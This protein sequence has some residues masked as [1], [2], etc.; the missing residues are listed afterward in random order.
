MMGNLRRGL[1]PGIFALLLLGCLGLSISGSR[2]AGV[3][4]QEGEMG[5]A[6]LVVVRSADQPDRLELNGRLLLAPVDSHLGPP[7]ISPDGRY[8]AVTQV[9]RGNET[10]HLAQIHLFD[11]AGG[12]G[13][14]PEM[15]PEMVPEMVRIMGHS[16]TWLDAGEGFTFLRSEPPTH[17]LAPRSGDAAAQIYAYDLRTGEVQP[18]QAADAPQAR[19]DQP[20]EQPPEQPTAAQQTIPAP[21]PAYPEFIR[22]AH[23]PE[24][25]CRNVPD[26]QVDLI[27]FEEYVARSVPAEVPVSWSLETLAA[28][29]VAARTYAWYQIRQN[30]PNYDVTDWANFQMMCDQR[31]PRS[32]LAVSLTAGQYLT[33]QDDPAQ[34]PIIAMY[35]AK[36]GHPTLD[37]PNVSYLRGVPDWAGLGE[38]RWG[39]GYGLSQWG[40]QRRAAV[41]QPYRQLL[42]HYYTGVHLQNALNPSQ[43][44]G[45]L[46]GLEPG[47][48][49]PPGGLRWASLTPRWPL[50]TALTIR[51]EPPTESAHTLP[52]TP[53]QI[54]TLSARSGVWPSLADLPEG[55]QVQLTLLVSDTIQDAITLTVDRTPPA[56]PLLQGPVEVET[57]TATV[58][59]EGEPGSKVGL[60]GGWRWPADALSQ[61]PGTGRLVNGADGPI[62]TAVAG[63]DLPGIWYGPYTQALPHGAT[64]RARFHLSLGDYAGLLPAESAVPGLLPDQP[65]ARLD[66]TDVGGTVRLG[67]RD[68]WPSDFDPASPFTHI[69]VDFHIFNPPEGLE[70]RVHW[71]G[72]ANL[73]L[74]QVEIFRLQGAT[75]QFTPL[76]L[77]PDSPGVDQVT[78]TAL[79]FDPA[80]NASPPVTHTIRIVDDGPP[81]L[82]GLQ[83]PQGWQSA[84]PLLITAQVVDV[85]SGLDTSRGR[86]VVGGQSVPLTFER[87]DAPWTEQTVSASVESLAEGVH[88]AFLSVYDMAGFELRQTF[89]L[90]VDRTPP[91]VSASGQAV[92]TLL[93][94]SDLWVNQPVTI[95]I[96]AQDAL[97]GI[98]DQG[99]VAYVL[100]QAPYA[101]YEGPFL[102]SQEGMQTIRYWARDRAENY[103]WSHF[104]RVGIDLTPPVVQAA[105]SQPVPG[106]GQISWQ[107]SDA[108]TGVAGYQVGIWAE[109]GWSVLAEGVAA[110]GLFTL[111]LDEWMADAEPIRLGVSAWDGVGNQ[112]DWQSALLTP[113]QGHWLYLPAVGRGE[114][115]RE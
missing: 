50:P 40:A 68:L 39:H 37:N 36:N 67:L 49:L 22:V 15:S 11:L 76:R 4:A 52:V 29:A 62:L 23:H 3:S 75:A 72:Q 71:M 34:R 44:L 95:T 89:Q 96:Q 7:R 63:E 91:T 108:W 105:I 20:P 56:S 16:V 61:T 66:V 12:S 1:R 51:V 28:Q 114:W 80:G 73:S 31:Y 93:P 25:G 59:I 103:T 30:R 99:G 86:V 58:Q 102:L 107:A 104:Y 33:A 17:G 69:P 24:N 35:S 21:P 60:S 57:L 38:V 55:S 9:P 46:F 94:D 48:Y 27:P 90:R 81:A 77:L 64:Y 19:G 65:I 5:E 13:A 32:D 112:S 74:A 92:A 82:M 47:G 78:V 97:S 87:A 83:V 88:D 10:A 42:G 84:L 79:A 14:S 111:D 26:W 43:P 113:G 109:D 110:G 54:L 70:F 100:N 45:G 53:T 8:V 2:W 41:G 85:S 98:P 115:G 101:Y 106:V 18:V 6:P